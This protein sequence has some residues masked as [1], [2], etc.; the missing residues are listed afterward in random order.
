M[1]NENDMNVTTGD[2]PA[3]DKLDSPKHIALA[4]VPESDEPP[5]KRNRKNSRGKK[6]KQLKTPKEPGE[7][8][9]GT[10]GYIFGKFYYS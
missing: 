3:D 6:D 10:R 2:H 8:T 5:K 4:T 1:N 9:Q 7:C